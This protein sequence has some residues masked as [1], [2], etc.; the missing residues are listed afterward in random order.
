MPASFQ[1]KYGPW[2]IVAG[3]S[4]GL[5]AAFAGA[6]A[7][8]GL[9]LILLARRADKLDEVA[10]QLQATAG[11]EVRTEALDLARP[12]IADALERVVAGVEVG[13]GVYNAAFAPVGAI[14]ER[15]LEDLTRV[16]DVSVRAPLV[17]ART[18]APAMVARG[19]G[20]LVLMSSLAGYQGSPRIATYAGAKAFNIVFGESLWAEL[21]PHG[22]DVVVSAAGAVRTPG[23]AAATSGDAPGTLDARVVAE[24][25]LDALGDGPVVSP[26]ATNRL[27]RFVMG[28]LLPRRTQIAI[29]ARSTEDLS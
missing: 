17:F 6:L 21:K 3:A 13:L 10:S 25:T 5:G 22:V 8:R 19:R 26:G 20:G 9:N 15:P 18:L 29:M 12:D 27:A 24:R 14:V 11:V 23:Y 1:S 28:R 7:A 4:V 2:A 16:V